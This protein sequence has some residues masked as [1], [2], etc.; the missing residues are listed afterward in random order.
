MGKKENLLT[1]PNSVLSQIQSDL[2]G[3]GVK[4]SG[5]IKFHRYT[6]GGIA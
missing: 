3:S 4:F 2:T 5:W 1:V 6:L